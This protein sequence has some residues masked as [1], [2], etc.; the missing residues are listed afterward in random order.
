MQISATG[1]KFWES[2]RRA[3]KGPQGLDQEKEALRSQVPSPQK[4]LCFHELPRK[5]TEFPSEGNS[6]YPDVSQEKQPRY[7]I[8]SL[9]LVPAYSPG[10]H[11][12][13]EKPPKHLSHSYILACPKMSSRCILE[14]L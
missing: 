6:V 1:Q 7:Q 8:L 5:P 13:T 14:N 12:C 10:F 4:N 11:I 9:C 3:T 2:G